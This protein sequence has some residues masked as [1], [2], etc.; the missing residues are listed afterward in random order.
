MSE[1][2]TGWVLIPPQIIADNNLTNSQKMLLGR[3]MGLSNKE[4]YC[5]A[6]NKWLGEQLGLEPTTVSGY[7]SKL[8]NDGYINRV[9]TKDDNNEIKER[10]LY[11]LLN[12]PPQN[13]QTPPQ[14]KPDTPPQNKPE[15]SVGDNSG[16][17]EEDVSSNEDKFKQDDKE[18]KLAEKLK[19]YVDSNT[20]HKSGPRLDSS[21]FQD[22]CTAIDRLHR[23]GPT[24][25]D[26]GYSFDEI[27]DLINFSQNDDFWWRNILSATKL[28]KKAY[29]LEA[30]MKDKKSKSSSNRREP[31]YVN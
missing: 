28:R 5:Y 25:E 18:Y 6:S 7:I 26:N 3:I 20:L 22:W 29:Q 4:G 31:E 30:Q 15:G 1:Q 21:C 2:Q 11:P 10:R 14:N 23:L 13:N 19:D 24:G 9:L 17:E 27:E 12:P 8:D 16:R